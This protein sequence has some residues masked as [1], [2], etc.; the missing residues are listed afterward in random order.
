MDAQ[1]EAGFI[2]D[3]GSSGSKLK[4]EGDKLIIPR[5]LVLRLIVHNHLATNHAS[6]KEEERTL[7]SLKFILPKQTTVVDIIKKVRDNCMH[8]GARPK[9]IRRSLNM[10]LLSK[11]P[12][13]IIHVDFLY[14]NK[15][16]N[17]LV[18]TDNATRK[19]CTSDTAEV[20]ATALLEFVGNFQILDNFTFYTDNGSY[21]AGKLLEEVS[22]SFSVQFTP[23]TNGT[24]EI[25]NARVIRLIRALRSEFRIYEEDIGKLTGV[26]MN[27]INNSPSTI[28]AGYSP[29]QLFMNTRVLRGAEMLLDKDTIFVPLKNEVRP[30]ND[31]DKKYEIYFNQSWN[32]DIRSPDLEEQN[33]IIG[34]TPDSSQTLC[35]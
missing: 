20:V 2:K 28:K 11:I 32:K 8:C 18:L 33:R 9:L 25:S 12:R 14:I 7:S 10:N 17:Y 5:P 6:I 26:I 13:E 30:S 21:F 24:A 35:S 34:Q 27:V 29:N 22:R 15:F 23:W 19:H 4:Y 1:K 31:V 16:T 3:V